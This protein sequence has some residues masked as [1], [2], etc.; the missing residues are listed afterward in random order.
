MAITKVLNGD[1]TTNDPIVM[2]QQLPTIKG[3]VQEP[4]VDIQLIDPPVDEQPQ[5]DLQLS[6][7]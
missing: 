6:G 4:T 2:E 5:K 3:G 7:G 1:K